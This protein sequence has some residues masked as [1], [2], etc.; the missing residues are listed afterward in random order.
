MS[1]RM[2]WCW[3]ALAVGCGDKAEDDDPSA[4]TQEE[5]VEPVDADGDGVASIETGGEDCDDEDPSVYPGAVEICD[6]VD[7]DCDGIADPTAVF[8]ADSGTITNLDETH[9]FDDPEAPAIIQLMEDGVLEFCNPGTAYVAIYAE[10][11]AVTVEGLSAEETVLDGGGIAQI[12][13][14]SGESADVELRSLTLQHGYASSGGAV[15]ISQGT[16]LLQDVIL[17]E[18][19]ASEGGGLATLNA[20]V[21][22]RNVLV[23][24]NEASY[25]GGILAEGYSL[26]VRDSVISFNTATDTNGGGMYLYYNKLDLDSSTLRGNDADMDGGGIYGLE[27]SGEIKS[28]DFVNN[29]PQDIYL[30]MKAAGNLGTDADYDF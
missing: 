29:S 5:E 10:E 20:T 6:L 11:S 24:K 26:T 2:L 28:S 22:L 9:V 3:C 15:K 17:Q 13:S 25:A 27:A 8:T 18:N 19:V 30:F 14:S 23:T 21:T 1:S 16:A 7:T 12:F 4:D